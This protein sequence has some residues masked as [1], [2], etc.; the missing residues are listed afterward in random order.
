[1]I[2]S[3]NESGGDRR[4]VRKRDLET[5]TRCSAKRPPDGTAI[6]G[7]NVARPSYIIRMSFQ[8]GKLLSDLKSRLELVPIASKLNVIYEIS[9]AKL[10]PSVRRTLL[11][12]C[13]ALAEVCRMYATSIST[14][15]S[16]VTSEST[17]GLH[18]FLSS[19]IFPLL[20][21]FLLFAQAYCLRRVFIIF[22]QHSFDVQ[23]FVFFLQF[24]ARLAR[25][26]RSRRRANHKGKTSGEVFS[27]KKH[28]YS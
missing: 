12:F 15:F 19:L 8:D 25:Q 10:E 9:L 5:E 1:M 17:C 13:L 20:P 14:C 18:T 11:L 26:C 22:H 7:Y 4:R 28:I 6:Q 16:S 23:L 3:S 2:T 27:G 21:P 24:F